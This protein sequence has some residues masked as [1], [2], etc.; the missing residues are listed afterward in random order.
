MIPSQ[1]IP[2]LASCADVAIDQ[3]LRNGAT[4]LG[5]KVPT[6]EVGFVAAVVLG[7]VPSIGQLWKAVLKP[8]G[9]SVSVS[10]IFCHQ[11]PKVR[12]DYS[13]GGRPRCE[14]A[15]LL[16]AVEDYTSGRRGDRIACLVQAKMVSA[17]GGKTLSDPGDLVQL[18][19][20]TRWPSFTLPNGYAPHARDF[21]TCAHP[22]A[23]L[24][25]GRYGLIDGQPDPDWFQQ[26]PA[27]TMPAGGPRLGTFLANMLETGQT[28]YGRLANGLADDWSYT[29]DELMTRTAAATF[30]HSETLTGRHRRGMMAMTFF[31]GDDDAFAFSRGDQPPPSGGRPEYSEEEPPEPG[32]SVLHIAVGRNEDRGEG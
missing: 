1:H 5:Q 18:D 7:A 30:S 8:A 10:G 32:I 27:S 16:V 21:S 17:L 3:A 14:L 23:T 11:S 29:V 26:L 20:L 15:D 9:Y 4:Y 31:A 28:G 25:C 12:F 2:I 19:L 22:G 13:G 6:G 24:D